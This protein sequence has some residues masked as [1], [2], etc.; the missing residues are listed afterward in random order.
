M[1][2][3]QSPSLSSHGGGLLLGG[4]TLIG[5]FPSVSTGILLSAFAGAVIFVISAHDLTLLQKTLLF[6]VSLTAGI[7]TAPF[8]AT[9]IS[10][11]T[12]TLIVAPPEVGA[13]VASTLAVRL[14]LALST[15]SNG[16]LR[17]WMGGGK[18]E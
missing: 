7:V 11:L 18:S 10:A 17:K 9:V 16:L 14:L 6:A 4:T 15:H 13:L 12:P 8:T 1:V 5:L 2:T 3:S